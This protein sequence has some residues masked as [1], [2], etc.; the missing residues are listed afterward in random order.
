VCELGNGYGHLT[1][2]VPLALALR[3]NGHEPLFI[4]NDLTKADIVLSPHRLPALPCPPWRHR[5]A[6]LPPMRTYTDILLR[7][8]FVDVAGLRGM[9]RAWQ[10]LAALSRPALMVADHSPVA[11]FAT[12]GG[13]L[14]R[15]RFGDGFCCPPLETPMPPF[16]WWAGGAV[17]FD[18]I[19][20]R[21]V[22][23]VA[24]QVAD[25]LGLPRAD[26]VAQMLQADAEFL[27]TFAELD[28]Y[29]A[30]DDGQYE[31]ALLDAGA[32]AAGPDMP[33]PAGDGPC[34]FVYLRADYPH[35]DALLA[36]VT[37]GG[38]RAVVHV[39]G[40]PSA[41]ANALS[42]DRVRL[43]PTPLP[44]N[45]VVRR[46]DA[47]ITHGGYGTTHALLLAGKPQLLLARQMEQ[48]MTGHRLQA[49]GAGLVLE[50]G[51]DTPD[52]TPLLGRL[53]DEAALA[54]AARDFADRHAAH[55]SAAT[56]A[57]LMQR[58]EGLM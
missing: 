4:V 31:G 12:R 24:N 14:P 57:A 2:L 56:V 41:R 54:T 46:C 36:A 9:A 53:R 47:G 39:P 50:L 49:L 13:G 38:W 1:R 28:H 17:P 23:H 55:D 40:L 58:C 8:G 19:A 43:S 26:S 52:F 29:G 25:E 7:H 33:W 32:A 6:G 37:Q 44:M 21:N 5:V 10:Q 30:R 15:L 22:V 20:E 34:A 45:V 11:L 27:C 18:T 48:T 16:A 42:N 35:L 3:E 51:A